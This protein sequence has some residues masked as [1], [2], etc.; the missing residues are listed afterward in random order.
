MKKISAAKLD[1]MIEEGDAQ[2]VAYAQAEENVIILETYDRQ[3]RARRQEVTVTG[4][5]K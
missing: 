1:R 2:I 5:N 4:W 3:G